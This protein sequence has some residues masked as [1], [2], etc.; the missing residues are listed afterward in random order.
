MIENTAEFLWKACHAY[1]DRPDIQDILSTITAPEGLR[2]K[3]SPHLG[4][5]W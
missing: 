1:Q 5:L 2:Q 3:W 4:D